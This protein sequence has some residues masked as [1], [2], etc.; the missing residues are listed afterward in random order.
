MGR[1]GSHRR[2]TRNFTEQCKTT[3]W[4]QVPLTPSS[5]ANWNDSVKNML[6]WLMLPDVIRFSYLLTTCSCPSWDAN[7]ISARPDIRQHQATSCN[8]YCTLLHS[9]VSSSCSYTEKT[10]SSTLTQSTSWRSNL[11]WATLLNVD[12]PSCLSPLRFP[13]KSSKYIYSVPYVLL[14]WYNT[15]FLFYHPDNEWRIY[16]IKLLTKYFSPLPCFPVTLRPKYSS[17]SSIHKHLQPM[18]LPQSEGLKVPGD[19][20]LYIFEKADSSSKTLSS[21]NSG[22]ANII[23]H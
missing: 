23:R 16:N 2:D 17:Q 11:I 4:F 5:E 9:K 15:F 8:N 3:A 6:G 12:L 21:S 1:F 18:F 10:Q 7:L 20:Y 13:N 19:L 22:S 14:E